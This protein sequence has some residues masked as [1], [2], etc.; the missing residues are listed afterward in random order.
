MDMPNQISRIRVIE[1]KLS[2]QEQTFF[3]QCSFFCLLASVSRLVQKES[4]V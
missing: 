1:K 3:L 4:M 2:P